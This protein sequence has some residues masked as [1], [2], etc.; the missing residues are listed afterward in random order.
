MAHTMA[1]RIRLLTIAALLA[2]HCPGIAQTPAGGKIERVAVQVGG[3]ERSYLRYVP[4]N[5]KP[6]QPLVIAL[7][8]TFQSGEAMRHETGFGFEKLSEEHGFVVAYPDAYMLAWNDCRRLNRTLAREHGVDDVAFL[9]EVIRATVASHGS[10]SSRV[11][12]FGFSGGGHM[13]YRMAWEAPRDIAALAAVAANLPPPDALTCTSTG[14]TPRVVMIKG[15]DDAG[16]PFDGG[17]HALSGSVLSAQASAASFARQ[18]GLAEPPAE[19]ELA[20]R[21]KS[22][23]W[24]ARGRALIELHSV[25]GLGHMVPV[26]WRD[27]VDGTALAWR[28]FTAP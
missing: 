17:P 25:T 4:A 22:H 8:G 5:A 27:K 10:D 15:R 23:A 24:P 9:R 20:A 2:L 3:V 21:T 1:P 14:P 16:D 11:F 19:V 6:G 7:H 13:A 28:F 12:L 18:N 26:E